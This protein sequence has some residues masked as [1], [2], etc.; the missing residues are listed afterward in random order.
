MVALADARIY[1]WESLER[2]RPFITDTK[3][4]SFPGELLQLFY[5]AWI[6]F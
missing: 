4:K 5:H 6:S 3:E 1:L 2:I